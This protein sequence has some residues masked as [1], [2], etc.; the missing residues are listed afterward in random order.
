MPDIIAM[1][2]SNIKFELYAI[3]V[4]SE[5][6][7]TINK[8]LNMLLPMIFP[9]AISAFPFLAAFTEVTSS[10][11]EVPRATIVRPINRSLKPMIFASSVAELTV[12]LLPSTIVAAPIDAARMRCHTG[13]VDVTFSS[14]LFLDK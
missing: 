3:G 11:R 5:E 2:P 8:I 7:P 12:T 4:I 10:G 13:F 14:L 6:A 1:I 9:M